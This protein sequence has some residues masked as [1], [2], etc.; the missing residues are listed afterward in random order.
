MERLGLSEIRV[1]TLHVNSFSFHRSIQRGRQILRSIFAKAI[2]TQ[3]EVITG[4]FNLFAS[5]QFQSDTG[6]AIFGG[7]VIETL[8]GVINNFNEQLEVKITY[9]VSS[10]TQPQ[11]VFDN[12]IHSDTSVNMDCMVFISI[13]YNKQQFD[14]ERPQPILDDSWLARDY[15]RNVLEQPRQLWNY[16]MCL[17]HT[18]GDWHIPLIVPVSAH[19]TRN[20][21][22]RGPEAQGQ[23][24]ERYHDWVQRQCQYQTRQYGRHYGGYPRQDTCP[25]SRS[26]GSELDGWYGGHY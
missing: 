18:D 26:S 21:R 13:V 10:S 12:V 2:M 3:V 16:D 20:K 25:Y 23:R 15:L 4:D 19:A 11:S 1:L 24:R 14:A 9:N 5:R 17:R 6:G 22:T 7:I 8:E